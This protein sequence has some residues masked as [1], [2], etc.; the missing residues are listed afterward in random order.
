MA[1]RN[2]GAIM[3]S[4]GTATHPEPLSL[5]RGPE[6]LDPPA[7]FSLW[8]SDAPLRRIALWNGEMAWVALSYEAVRA[9][10]KDSARFRSQPATPGFPTI[11]QADSASKGAALLPM[12]DPPAHTVLREAVLREF[13][14]KRIEALRPQAERIVGELLD[15]MA[16]AA[17]PVDLVG[18][19]AAPVP[20]TFTCLLLGVPLEDAAFFA[21]CLD[22]RFTPTSAA[23]AVYGADDRLRQYFRDLVAERAARPRD[24]LSSRLVTSSVLTGKISAEDAAALL[25][26]LLIGGFDTTKQMIALSTVALLDYPDQLAELMA[27]PALWRGAVQELLRYIS[28]AQVERRACV[29]DTEVCGQLIRAGEGV[30]VLLGSANRDPD[31]FVDPDRFDIRRRDLPHVA[32]GHGIHQ[33]LGQPVARMLLSVTLPALFTRYPRLSLAAP[34]EELR[35]REDRSIIGIPE[36]PVRIG[37]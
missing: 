11:N 7:H 6:K 18:A 21:R 29:A 19:L 27:E 13:I 5:V 34:L 28:V 24:D 22:V 9:V 1:I 20:A 15:A 35:F 36:L 16:G 26:V 10:F 4:T 8:R 30:L 2:P 31:V 37:A 32:F 12:L 3:T 33:C 14:V 17:A 25:H 23:E